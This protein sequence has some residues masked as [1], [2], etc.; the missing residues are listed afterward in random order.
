[1]NLVSSLPRSL[2]YVSL[3]LSVIVLT[4][5]HCASTQI[6]PC[7]REAL[8]CPL[9]ICCW[10]WFFLCVDSPSLVVL[11]VGW[12]VLFFIIFFFSLR[13]CHVGDVMDG[14]TLSSILPS[15][16]PRSSQQIVREQRTGQTVLYTTLQRKKKNWIGP[17]TWDMRITCVKHELCWGVFVEDSKREKKKRM[18][19]GEGEGNRMFRTKPLSH[20]RMWIRSYKHGQPLCAARWTVSLLTIYLVKSRS[21]RAI[22]FFII[23]VIVVLLFACYL[24][25]RSH[26]V[27]L[28]LPQKKINRVHIN[29]QEQRNKR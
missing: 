23:I 28:V 24:V 22:F 11:F 14:L 8:L 19:E 4:V 2:P 9:P 15:F 3:S 20:G 27:L 7:G 13:V 18:G 29:Q 26:S 1:M 12:A 25:I 16:L 10:L 17:A 5:V 21:H 6:E